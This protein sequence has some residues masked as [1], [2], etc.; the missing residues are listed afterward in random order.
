MP[1]VLR[2]TTAVDVNG[3][4][5]GMAESS[6]AVNA[7]A[8]QMKSSFQEV[9]AVT[10]SEM[11]KA[12]LA[13]RGLGEEIGVR[14]P[15]F[16]ANYITSIQGAAPILASAFS[17][18]ALLGFVTVAAQAAEKIVDIATS[19]DG[20]KAAQQRALDASKGLLKDY[21]ETAKHIQDEIYKAAEHRHG[22]EYRLELEAA[23][24]KLDLT[25]NDVTAIKQA[26]QQ[27]E[28]LRKAGVKDNDVRITREQ[29]ALDN[30]YTKQR[31]DAIDL[32]DLQSQ[33]ADKRRGDAKTL[34]EANIDAERKYDDASIATAEKYVTEHARLGNR[35]YAEEF[36]DLKRISDQ[37][38]AVEIAY[39]EKR[40]TLAVQYAKPGQSSTPDITKINA[41]EFAAQKTHESEMDALNVK[42][43]EQKKEDD[44]L[45][46]DIFWS[47]LKQQRKYFEEEQQ[48]ELELLGKKLASENAAAATVAE[49]QIAHDKHVYEASKAQLAQQ[50]AD[51]Q[52]NARQE[53]EQ[54][55][56]VE[57]ARHAAD[58]AVANGQVKAAGDDPEKVAR[59]K[60]ELQALNDQ[61]NTTMGKISAS[62]QQQ[63]VAPFVAAVDKMSGALF[64]GFNSWI[65]GHEKFYKAAQQTWHSLANDAL[66]AVEKI[67]EH[68][69]AKQVAMLV[70]HRAMKTAEVA[71]DSTAVA[72]NAGAKAAQIAA[73]AALADSA[74]GLAATE[75]AAAAAPA[76]PIAAIAAGATM[77]AAMA[78]YVAMASFDQGGIMPETGLAQ[79]HANEM[80]LPPSLSAF[81]Q[82]AAAGASYDNSSG[83]DTHYHAAPGESPHSI[84]RN[85]AALK[86]A[87]REGRF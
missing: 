50:L 26:Q 40:K 82:R 14:M 59:A 61:F 17:T 70:A 34:A 57:I 65:T 7:G 31:S 39:Q 71:V 22:A 76:G 21:E 77:V 75:A 73:N 66:Q 52:I 29:N 23:D 51:R 1:D 80:V 45:G 3:I 5:A 6:A 15:R 35:S 62:I 54:L 56:Q 37:K 8:Q 79:V 87:K 13:I 67:A 10:T 64:S 74:A 27:I 46:L 83:R 49:G 55:R 63:M 4:R 12:R 60:N 47:T 44:K 43:A 2:I 20:V 84:D 28:D 19:W 48:A 36:A 16:V 78:P 18:I 24:K 72:A 86:K 41:E 69:I 33:I 30:A 25:S 53:L 32:A 11:T 81:V 38:L 9:G 42:S 68:Y 58:S 85:I